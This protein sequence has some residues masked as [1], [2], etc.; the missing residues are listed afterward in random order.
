MR[1][2]KEKRVNSSVQ[3][4]AGSASRHISFTYFRMQN[5]PYRKVRHYL[6]SLQVKGSKQGPRAF[7]SGTEQ[8]SALLLS[9]S[10]YP[11]LTL[12]ESTIENGL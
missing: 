12:P 1:I 7:K 11:L 5:K 2:K 6:G 4:P 3:K 10:P 8:G 9:C